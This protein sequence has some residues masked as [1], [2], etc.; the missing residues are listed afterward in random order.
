MRTHIRLFFVGVLIISFASN[1]R[2]EFISTQ[3]GIL[4]V[5]GPVSAIASSDTATYIGGTFTYAGFFTGYAVPISAT[6]GLATSTYPKAPRTT[7]VIIPDGD[8]G[9]YVGGAFTSFDGVARNAVAH[10]LAN[11]SLDTSFA[12]PVFAGTATVYS[13]ILSPDGNTLYVGGDFSTVGGVAHAN[14][15]ALNTSDGTASTTFANLNINGRVEDLDISTDGATLY[16][17]GFFTS[18]GGSTRTYVAAVN[19]Y[20][21]TLISGFNT[22]IVQ[23]G[24]KWVNDIA[25]S[26]DG[27]TL[28]IGGNFTTVNG[29]TYNRLAALSTADGTSISAFNPNVS[30]LT[31][32]QVYALALSPDNSIVYFGGIFNSVGG[33][34][35]TRVAAVQASDG[36]VVSAFNPNANNIV[37]GMA[38]SPDGGTLY[39]SGMFTS[40]G[41]DT[42]YQALAAVNTSTGAVV[43]SFNPKLT[44]AET[45]SI[46]ADG[47]LLY[48]IPSYS[49]GGYLRN[50]LAAI[51][52]AGTEI[53]SF[54]PNMN[55]TVN[56]LTLSPD[57][58][59]VYAGGSFTT[60][61]GTTYNRL[62]ALNPSTGAAISSFNPNINSTVSALVVSS[63]GG[64]VYAGG[65]FTTV[66]GVAYNR[67]AA[68]SASDG[69]AV[70]AFNPN[71][72]GSVNALALSSNDA[73]L[74]A[75]GAFTTVGGITR[76]RLVALDTSNG[77]SSTSFNPDMNN[78]VSA[79]VLSPDNTRLYAGGIF[80]T[81]GGSTYNRLAAISTSN[82][83]AISS[84][85][86][87]VSGGVN[88]LTLTS[89]GSK[90]YAA[91]AYGTVGGTS[92]NALASINTADGSLNTTFNSSIY[93]IIV[94][95]AALNAASL[96]ATNEKLY[97]GGANIVDGNVSVLNT[98]YL[99][100]F[101]NQTL[102]LSKK[103]A[104]VTDGATSGDTY[105]IALTAQPSADVTV[106]LSTSTVDL[107]VSPQTLTFTSSNW[108][109]P[110]SVTITSRQNDAPPSTRTGT[111]SHA[112]SSADTDFTAGSSLNV[113]VT[114][115]E[116]A[117]GLVALSSSGNGG[118]GSRPIQFSTPVPTPSVLP[119]IIPSLPPIVPLPV[120]FIPSRSFTRS[121]A[122][123]TVHE[124]VRTLQKYLNSLGFTVA[125]SGPGSPGNETNY[126][127]PATQ[128]AVAAFQKANNIYPPAGFFGALT[129]AY[130]N[131]LASTTREIQ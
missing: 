61:G 130:M 96:S 129:R 110:Q 119:G 6:T 100:V 122:T 26:T 118:G 80:T 30:G 72:G 21:G 94:G 104:S 60:V 74:Y 11:G 53:L 111:I 23:T 19:A 35:Y 54:N 27:T 49:I 15:V 115:S 41:G 124:E 17:G 109:T 4:Y 125:S 113:T 121:L 89:D 116:S 91:G 43:P 57:Q 128:K 117:V 62:V 131:E 86:P 105:T 82:G 50:N 106:T 46:S 9:Y 114:I 99:N 77:T 44:T 58:S 7:H 55:A 37:L 39:L 1:A 36:A 78:T 5:N 90:I 40:I 14:L 95:F 2:A 65:A 88:A 38:L 126:F 103:T 25:L 68:V 93:S 97:I 127:G 123:R 63:E 42:A 64:T 79:L 33:G 18:V 87:N 85:N 66:G 70:S 92:R 81:V 56:S 83:S 29:V 69:T 84:F 59:R 73:T 101:S 3:E 22:T 8:G 16:L 107:T 76:N 75:G 52:T 10:V 45:L 24:G 32:S 108:N 13:L 20:A 67:L 34:T 71:M 51:N 47:S 98:P 31:D 12:P 48:T 120:I 102:S 112:L 28:Y